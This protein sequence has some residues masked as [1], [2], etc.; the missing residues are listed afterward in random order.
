MGTAATRL[1]QGLAE[2][3]AVGDR[4]GMILC[5]AGLGEVEMARDRPGEALRILGEAREH[6]AGGLHGN[7]SD[8]LLIPIGKAR[9]RL[10]D[11]EGA[12]AD[13]ERGVHIAGRIGEFDDEA[14]GYLT[15]G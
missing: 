1:D 9:A 5:L 12:Q 3:R 15:L 8:M 11:V 10:G 14:K 7:F 13:L 4:W 2:F 6:A